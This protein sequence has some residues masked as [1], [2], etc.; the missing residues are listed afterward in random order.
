MNLSRGAF[1]SLIWLVALNMRSGLIVIGPVMPGMRGDLVLTATTAALLVSIPTLMMGL[2]ASPAG[3]LADRWGPTRT[4]LLGLG[5]VALGG[6]LR[7][8]AT[9]WTSLLLCT[10]LFGIG[11]GVTEPA[12]PRLARGLYPHRVGFATGVYGSGFIVGAILVSFVTVPFERLFAPEAGWRESLL[13]WGAVGLLTMLVWLIAVRPLAWSGTSLDDD[14]EAE[15]DVVYW[16]PWRDRRM[17]LVAGLFGSQGIAFYLLAAWLPAVYGDLGVRS[18][19]SVALFTAFN[20]VTFPAVLLFPMVSD[21]MESRRIPNLVASVMVLIGGLGLL[22]APVAPGLIW[23]WPLLCGAGIAGL[24]AM[25]LLLPADV[26]PRGRVGAAAGMTLA[27]G[28]CASALGPLIAGKVYDVTGSLR[29]ALIVLPVVGIAM[30]VLSIAC[31]D[32][33]RHPH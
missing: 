9:D 5:L 19:T 32:R 8:L 11:M 22:L 3:E 13:L 21:R 28:Y 14:A 24:L 29:T 1:L 10:V 33:F 15:E 17:W 26:A 31:P 2:T 20:V 12:L 7:G 25:A 4:V 18:A 27:I 30:A 23:V 6:G 16:H